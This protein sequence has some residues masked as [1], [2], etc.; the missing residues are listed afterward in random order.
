MNDCTWHI[1]NAPWV[2]GVICIFTSY[3]TQ[4]FIEHAYIAVCWWDNDEWSMIAAHNHSLSEKILADS[5]TACSRVS[6]MIHTSGSMRI[7]YPVW[8]PWGP[9]KGKLTRILVKTERSVWNPVKQRAWKCPWTKWLSLS[10]NCHL[11]SSL[12]VSS[13]DI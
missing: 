3:H 7:P 8:A 1:G 13:G 6:T 9:T 10:T 12:K 4:I 2:L 11:A 5:P